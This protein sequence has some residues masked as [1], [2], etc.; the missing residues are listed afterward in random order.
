MT[1]SSAHP[2]TEPKWWKEAT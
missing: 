1:I 2:E